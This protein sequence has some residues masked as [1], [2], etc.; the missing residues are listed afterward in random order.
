M[1]GLEQYFKESILVL[2]GPRPTRKT[3][4]AVSRRV[5]WRDTKEKIELDP[6]YSKRRLYGS[7]AFCNGWI[8]KKDLDGKTILLACTIEDGWDGVPNLICSN[9]TFSNYWLKTYPQ[10]IVRK[11]GNDLC[12]ICYKFA[13]SQQ[14]SKKKKEN[15]FRMQMEMR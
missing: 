1:P 7:Y 9:S 11:P 5:V 4:D 14:H 15:L 10:L 2:T 3:R 6:G 8:V 12:S 13:R